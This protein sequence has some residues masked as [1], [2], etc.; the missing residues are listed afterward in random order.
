[1]NSIIHKDSQMSVAFEQFKDKLYHN[2]FAFFQLIALQAL[3]YLFS[4]SSSMTGIG[5]QHFML[6]IRHI[7]PIPLFIMSVLWI[8]IQAF[9]F[10]GEKRR[11]YYMVSNNFTAYFSDIAVLE[12]YAVI[13][14]I[15]MVFSGPM[16][17][18]LGGL[19]LG[20]ASLGTTYDSM[21]V[22]HYLS[23][24]ITTTF[25][26]LLFGAA[27]YFLGILRIRYQSFFVISSIGFIL[28]LIVGSLLGVRFIGP[29]FN[30]GIAGVIQFYAQESRIILWLIKIIGS[31]GALYG[32]IWLGIKNLEVNK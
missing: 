2:S 8:V 5:D 27:A 6:S 24:F 10:S 16:L 20:N 22:L 15:T 23:L 13:I 4:F 7:S 30:I 29:D 32:L 25:Y 28:L 1:M 31:I 21:T 18:L 11:E 17:Q 12:I 3:G 14:G 26:S 19:A 9:G